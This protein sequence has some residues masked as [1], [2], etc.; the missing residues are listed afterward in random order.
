MYSLIIV[1]DKV[2][3]VGKCRQC[4]EEYETQPFTHSE[5]LRWRRGLEPIQNT[6]LGE[7]LNDDDREFL[8]SNVSPKGWRQMHRLQK[9]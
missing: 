5:Y 4:K 6:G 3:A 2:K 9:H 1:G 8:I 7:E